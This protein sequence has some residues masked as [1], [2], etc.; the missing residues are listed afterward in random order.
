LLCEAYFLF[1]LLSPLD[2]SGVALGWL[3][4]WGC[5]A[6]ITWEQSYFRWRREDTNLE[7]SVDG[8]E[9]EVVA[10]P[11]S[12][13]GCRTSVFSLLLA[14]E[15]CTGETTWEICALGLIGGGGGGNGNETVGQP[16]W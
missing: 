5:I 9:G 8:L 13:T 6:L 11:L 15:D 10:F 3:D 1:S 14:C 2:F 16:R 4:P 12:S 7:D